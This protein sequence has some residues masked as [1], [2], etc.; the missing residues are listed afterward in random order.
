[1]SIRGTASR[2]FHSMPISI[3]SRP[4]SAATNDPS[5]LAAIRQQTNKIEHIIDQYA[6]LAAP[7]NPYL[8]AIG[9][10]FIV[11]TFLEDTLRIVSQWSDQVFYLHSFRHI[12]R[13]IVVVFLICNIIAMSAGSYLVIARKYTTYAVLALIFVVIS[14]ALFY[15]LIFELKFFLRNLSVIGGL[16]LVLSSSLAR[17]KIAFAGLPSV[18][19]KDRQMYFQLAGRILL[20]L[21]FLNFIVTGGWSFSRVCVSLIG[22]VACTMVAVGFKTRLSAMLLTVI[23]SLFNVIINHYWT[24][25][26]NH[27]N[28]DFLKY[29]FFQTLSI[30]GGL[31]LVVNTGAGKLSI[32]EKKKIY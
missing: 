26:G 19:E 20:V 25:S 28:R 5:P 31:L 32:D 2:Q 21:L 22:F 14:Q 18:E 23:L 6:S 7:I 16:L 30:V 12:P 3:S 11:A 17:P 9:R 13:F 29:E 24:Y 15:G 8:P 1:M 27:P 10:F 4:S